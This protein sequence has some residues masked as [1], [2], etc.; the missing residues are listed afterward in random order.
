MA[1]TPRGPDLPVRSRRS[2][3]TA[4]LR[5]H[6]WIGIGLFVLLVPLGATGSLSAL[7][8]LVEAAR[9]PERRPQS[10]PPLA[11]SYGAYQS[12]AMD[13]FGPGATVVSLSFRPGQAVTAEGTV[14]HSLN[15]HT[16]DQTGPPVRLTAWL[17]PGTARVLAVQ[18]RQGPGNDVMAK[19]HRWH[20]TLM[21]GRTGRRAVGVLGVVMLIQAITGLI[22]WTP[23]AAALWFG[24]R[25]RRS[26]ATLTNLHY[27]IGF[28]T[29]W[30]LA[31]LALTGIGLSFPQ[32]TAD[33]IGQVAA[34]VQ[35]LAPRGRTLFA[36]RLNPDQAAALALA[37]ETGARIVT[38]EE[39]TDSSPS[40]KFD[41]VGGGHPPVRLGVN[42][43][44]GA[45]RVIGEKRFSPG[46]VLQR[47][48]KQLHG[49]D[50]EGRRWAVWRWIA[51]VTGFMPLVLALAGLFAFGLR[52]TAR[53]A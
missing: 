4:W 33:A 2:L 27:L 14:R 8:P 17:D 45:V 48:I 32:V 13:A 42:D 44:S 3:R 7:R 12:A 6:Q 26:A 43:D 53:T 20:E 47:A 29:A 1:D 22:L 5:I 15:E 35:R 28:W 37:G 41:V 19:V 25:W 40:W 34:P 24:L 52:Q 23:P 39:P 16:P 49:A 10:P 50:G 21:L 36:S 46:N 51:I 11:P 31:F 9:H 30:P 38:L 18:R